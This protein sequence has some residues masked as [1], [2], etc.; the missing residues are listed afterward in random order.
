M[1][2]DTEKHEDTDLPKLAPRSGTEPWVAHEMVCLCSFPGRLV[3]ASIKY[4]TGA[5]IPRMLAVT[6]I[7]LNLKPSKYLV[8]N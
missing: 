1:P 3:I 6:S 5:G 7:Q 2:S 8:L 4:S